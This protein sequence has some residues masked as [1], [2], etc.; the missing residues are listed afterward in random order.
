M[1]MRFQLKKVDQIISKK[2][3]I[4]YLIMRRYY[5]ILNE[6]VNQDSNYLKRV[7]LSTPKENH[8]ILTLKE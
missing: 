8:I 4:N 1:R 6:K 3:W 7:I 5:L 2:S